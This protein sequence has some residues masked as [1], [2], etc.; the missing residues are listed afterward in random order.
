[1]LWTGV[2]QVLWMSASHSLWERPPCDALMQIKG[3]SSPCDLRHVK[4]KR[5][6]FSPSLCRVLILQ[7]L[8]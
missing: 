8:L 1:M 2:M 7:A 3:L 6:F 4:G 5:S